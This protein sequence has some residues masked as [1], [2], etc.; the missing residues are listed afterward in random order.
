MGGEDALDLEWS[1]VP[2]ETQGTSL[3]PPGR[4]DCALGYDEETQTLFVDGGR[5]KFKGRGRKCP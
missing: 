4:T 5:G 2:V 1:A 3:P